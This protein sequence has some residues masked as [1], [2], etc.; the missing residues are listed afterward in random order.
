MIPETQILVWSDIESQYSEL[1]GRTVDG[2]TVYD[3]LLGWSELSKTVGETSTFLQ[4]AADLDTADQTAQ[5]QLS[6]FHRVT[7]P[8]VTI[9]DA[10]LRRKVLAVREPDIPEEANLVLRRMQTDESAYR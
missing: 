4:L 5:E 2:R 8:A 1:Q 10:G 9:A 6:H 3:F 7:Q